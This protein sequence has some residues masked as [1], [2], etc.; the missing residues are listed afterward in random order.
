MG[1]IG[2]KI[3]EQ[4][5]AK[6]KSQIAQPAKTEYSFSG[7]GGN[8][9]RD[10]TNL[11][12]GIVGLGYQA[13]T[14]PQK[15]YNVVKSSAWEIGKE[16]PAAAWGLGK[17]ALGMITSPIS[18]TK[19]AYKS[20]QLLRDVPYSEQKQ[21]FS[22]FAEKA[23]REKE[24]GEKGAAVFGS[25]LLGSFLM[26][27]THPMDYFYENPFTMTLDALTLGKASGVN[28]SVRIAANKIPAVQKMSSILKETFTPHGKLINA[29][30]GELAKDFMKTKSSL[31]NVQKSIVESTANKFNKVFKLSNKERLDFFNTI[32][33]LR[34]AKAGVVAK[35]SNLKVQKAIDWWLTKEVPKLQRLTGLSKDKAITNYLHHFF[36]EKA[37]GIGIKPLQISTKGYLKKSKD[38]E[39][40][41]KEPILSISAIK[42]RVATDAIKD[43]FI[44][45]TIQKYSYSMD[46]IEKALVRELGIDEV[47]KLKEAGRL[48]DKAMK[49]FN[50]DEYKPKGTL[51]FFKVK[52]EPA[53]DILK[54]ISIQNEPF[55]RAMIKV[56]KGI[57]DAI[58]EG[59]PI[60]ATKKFRKIAGAYYPSTKEIKL[61]YFKPEVL[62]HERGHSWDYME[63]KLSKV[64]NTKKIFQKELKVL[65]DK[66][67]GGTEAQRAS[68]TEKWAVF[69][70]NYIHNPKFVKEN[71]PMFTSYFK[72]KLTTDYKFKEAY[73]S[74]SKQ[75]NIINKTVKNIKPALLKADKGY[76]ETAIKTAFPSKEFVGVTKKVETHLM[77]KIVVDELTKFTTPRSGTMDK[78]LFPFD[79]FNRNW[80]PLA[81]AVR[82]RYHTRNIVGNL[83][84]AI[85]IGKTSLKE[86]PIALL[87]QVQHHI[88]NSIKTN[89]LL[90]KVYK[91]I[92]GKN[93]PDSKTIK[94]AIDND[95]V[96]RGFFAA[97][98]NDISKAVNNA[99]DIMKTIKN[100]KKP[101]EI[102]KIPILKEYLR[103]SQKVG[104]FLEDNARLAMFQ[105]GL[106]KYGRSMKGITKSKDYV[107]EHL[108]D[109]I[110]GLSETDRYIKRLVP[111][112]AWTRFNVPLQLKSLYKV[113]ERHLTLQKAT[114]APTA[115]MEK[116]DE[117]YKYLGEKQK[118][119]GYFKVG[120]ILKNGK[121][122]NKYI[123]TAS[124]LP[125]QD[126]VKLVNLFRGKEE[127]IGLTPL[128][129]IYNYI[130]DSPTEVLNYWGQPIEQFKGEKQKFLGIAMR[131]KYKALLSTIPI[132]TELN[133]LIGGSYTEEKMP[134]LKNRL[135]TVLSPTGL[136]LVDPE[137]TKFFHELEKE[138]KMK[139]SWTGGWTSLYKKNFK[140]Y[141][142]SKEQYAKDN[143]ETLEKLLTDNGFNRTEIMKLKSSA[144]KSLFKKLIREKLNRKKPNQNK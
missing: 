35:S 136:A 55:E 61:K 30:Y 113:P 71:A 98:I 84:N 66:Y 44:H 1:I 87:K 92:L 67:Y 75:I 20:Y 21:L 36:P 141:R 85:V 26:E 11:T 50:L 7:F 140:V 91:A 88:H 27:T 14:H 143:M 86:I 56:G 111:F 105:Q 34:R 99:D 94:L 6:A 5:A 103:L 83:Y 110:T 72:K 38:V 135:E 102:Y 117:G 144:I 142:E 52:T 4:I 10:I 80:K 89:N 48:K 104:E 3:R 74:A 31:Y 78:L 128:V 17:Q 106:K 41:S 131:G 76:L 58:K 69:I 96:G 16:T 100:V 101:A 51:R 33:K 37:K 53:E 114:F 62:L 139:G 97:D 12:K 65:T 127:E 13:I 81:T 120:T 107:N 133:K 116:T 138:K 68:A 47:T 39:G 123:K 73:Q 29:G 118:E 129:Q 9:V 70:D 23:M 18:E 134:A 8:L 15:S 42:S 46:D 90:G 32:D 79:V 125:Q 63:G 49:V 112:W 40:F 2:D 126:L 93:I 82:P 115:E 124:V 77:P 130:L 25:G 122:Y 54:Q 28:K 22:G 43:S 95:V 60:S 137:T 119:S 108:F 64:I 109:Y 59:I 45:R 24:L 121:E 19:K 132:L 57:Q